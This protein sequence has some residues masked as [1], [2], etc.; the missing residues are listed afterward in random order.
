MVWRNDRIKIKIRWP[1]GKKFAFTIFDD[2]DNSFIHNIKPVYNL[3]KECRIFTT[4]SV[5]VNPVRDRFRGLCLQDKNYLNYIKKLDKEGFEIALHNVGSGEYV[6]DE[7]KNGIE[8]FKKCL[9]YYPTI[10]ANHSNNPDNIFW[11]HKRHVLPLSWVNYLLDKRKFCGEDPNSKFFWGDLSKRHIKYIRN[12]VFNGINTYTHDPKMPYR[13]RSKEKYS[14]YWFSSSDGHE[15]KGFNNLIKEENIINLEKVGGFCIAYTHFCG[16]FVDEKGCL[17]TEFEENI[18]RLSR[19]KNGWFV[20]VGSLLD[21]LLSIRET[22]DYVSYPYL[23]RLDFIWI[24][25]RI[26]KRLAALNK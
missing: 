5:W 4:K 10:H 14:N 25:H 17:N 3:L 8:E 15:V 11:G 23:A 6:R 26:I 9:G 7:I 24:I 12:L 20:P 22:E 13:I 19:N 18:R 21:F 1:E 16:G 2:T